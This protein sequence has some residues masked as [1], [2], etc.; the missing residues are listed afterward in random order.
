MSRENENKKEFKIEMIENATFDTCYEKVIT[1]SK[2]LSL[3]IN[4]IFVGAYRDYYG[5]NLTPFQQPNMGFQ[6]FPYLYFEVLPEA[7][8]NNPDNVCAFRAVS[9]HNDD[10][11]NKITKMAAIG[12]GGIDAAVSIT[13]DGKQGLDDFFIRSG[14]SQIKWTDVYSVKSVEGKTF[15]CV[16]GLDMIPLLKKI[17]GAFDEEGGLYEYEIEPIRPINGDS[18]NYG[19]IQSQSQN[20]VVNVNRCK[21]KALARAAESAG[22]VLNASW[23]IPA[24]R[25]D[26]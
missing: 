3:A 4:Q 8:Y 22:V 9:K 24:V 11:L 2:K 21:T 14:S 26:R 20:W 12:L 1:T 23:Q 17:Y 16:R 18:Y 19:Q 15:V 5:C 25:A 6:I 13:D 10:I 7:E